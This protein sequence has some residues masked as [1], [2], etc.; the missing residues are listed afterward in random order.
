MKGKGMKGKTLEKKKQKFIILKVQHEKCF[1]LI[2]LWV[3][4]LWVWKFVWEGI[5]HKNWNLI[6]FFKWNVMWEFIVIS[7]SKIVPLILRLFSRMQQVNFSIQSFQCQ[8]I[9]RD[10]QIWLTN[11]HSINQW[12][13]VNSSKLNRLLS[14]WLNYLISYLLSIQFYPNIQ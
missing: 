12:W 13:F 8:C 10:Q 7:F 4:K 2:C 3:A 6:F 5:G 9:T 14:I 11:Y 1:Y